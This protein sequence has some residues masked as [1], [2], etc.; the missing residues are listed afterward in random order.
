MDLRLLGR[1]VHANEDFVRFRPT[2]QRSCCTRRG[3]RLRRAKASSHAYEL[4]AGG[5]EVLDEPD[6]S[7][8]AMVVQLP[9]KEIHL[10]DLLNIL[11]QEGR[12][13]DLA[14][15]SIDAIIDAMVP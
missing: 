7:S 8:N 6:E 9:E 5:D 14:Q 11:K 1:D 3:Y 4:I 15:A 12:G 10:D 2:A 13:S